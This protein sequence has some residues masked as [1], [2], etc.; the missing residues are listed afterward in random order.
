MV[1]PRVCGRCGA[2]VMAGATSCAYCRVSF[3]EPAAA[4]A[5]AAPAGVDPEIVESL[6]R[7]NTIEAIRLY[8]LKT[9]SSLL[10]AKN[11]VEA[12]ARSLRIG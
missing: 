4:G 12:L 6:R 9:K 5:P 2:P 10:D 3:D 11:A 1:T 8:R 7:G